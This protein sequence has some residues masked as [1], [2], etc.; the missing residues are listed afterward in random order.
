MA[1]EGD[2]YLLHGGFQFVF[3]K[4]ARPNDYYLPTGVKQ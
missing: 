4:V 1:V 2:G 3:G